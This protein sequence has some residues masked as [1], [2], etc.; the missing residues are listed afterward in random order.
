[1]NLS[2]TYWLLVILFGLL[3]QSLTGHAQETAAEEGEVTTIVSP[4]SKDALFTGTASYKF[5]VK[6]TYNLAQEGT[7]SYVVLGAKGV[8]VQKDSVKVNIPKKGATSY[9]FDIAGLKTGF[10]KINFMINVSYYDDTTRKSFGIRPE[11]IRSTHQ[12]PADFDQFWTDA[13]TELARIPP[14]FKMTLLP[15][16]IKG[17]NRKGYL[18]EMRSLDSMVI[19]GYLTVPKRKGKFAVLVG[20]PGYQVSV[21]PLYGI[22]DDI[23]IFTL[24]VRGQGMSQDIIALPREMFI[25]YHLE[26]KYKYVMRGVIMDCIR[27]IDF[28]CS[29]PE[30][31]PDRIWV[32][33]GSMGGFLAIASAALDDRIKL[34]STQNP[35]MSD[36][37]NLE[38]EVE[39]PVNDLKQYVKTQPGLTYDMVLNTLDYF[40]TKNFASRVKCPTLLGIGLLDN[41][42]PPNNAYVVYNN[43]RVKSKHII[44]FK[45]LGHEIGEEYINYNGRWIRDSFGLF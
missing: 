21:K 23:A 25:S 29:R 43:L 2:K 28:I 14:D 17:N 45:D 4:R 16:T 39:W 24:D 19:R 36:V 44:V 1:M 42:V 35:I 3:T 30:L 9:N 12:E 13:R 6:N 40:D 41:L 31:D 27:A 10:Y 34:C 33:G 15:D 38:G 7:I 26:N 37:R 5:E 18:V 20:L 11:E 32:S 22:D 8:E